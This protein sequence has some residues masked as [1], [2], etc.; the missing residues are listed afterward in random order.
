MLGIRGAGSRVYLLPDPVFEIIQ[1]RAAQVALAVT[2][3]REELGAVLHAAGLRWPVP[4]R[5]GNTHPFPGSSA[6]SDAASDAGCASAAPLSRRG[7]VWETGQAGLSRQ[8]G[9][10]E[11]LGADCWP[12]SDVVG[13][14]E[15]VDSSNNCF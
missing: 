9:T 7:K 8:Y 6:C 5:S 4:C 1:R 2:G 15:G 10:L 14:A 11:Q 3:S 13:P 12:R